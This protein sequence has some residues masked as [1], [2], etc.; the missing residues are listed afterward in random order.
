MESFR[1]K[2]N[3]GVVGESIKDTSKNSMSTTAYRNNRGKMRME[4]AETKESV[5]LVGKIQSK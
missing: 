3:I 1:I 5:E 2:K 4:T